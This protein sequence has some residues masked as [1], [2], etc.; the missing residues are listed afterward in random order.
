MHSL[1]KSLTIPDGER[2]RA[3]LLLGTINGVFVFDSE[4][5]TR[6][7]WE[8]VHTALKESF[9]S[10][11]AVDLNSPGTVYVGAYHQDVFRSNDFGITWRAINNGLTTKDI[12]SLALSHDSK[13]L[14]AGTQPPALFKSIDGGNTWVELESFSKI[15]SSRHWHWFARLGHSGGHVLVLLVDP[16]NSYRIYAGVEQGGLHRSNDK[17]ASW[18]DIGF[19]LADQ[20]N[21]VDPH[22]FVLNPLQ[23]K[24]SYLAD[25]N[26]VSRSSDSGMNFD[27]MRNGLGEWM[28]MSP[29][30]IHPTNPDLVFVGGSKKPPQIWSNEENFADGGL[31]R[32]EDGCETWKKIEN[33][34]P[35]ILTST[36]SALEL[37]VING[38]TDIYCGNTDGEVYQSVDMGE[39][40]KK[41]ISGV[42][43]ITKWGWHM[44]KQ[45]GSED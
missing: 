4:A 33:G 14:Y 27:G 32:S 34:L 2:E 11:L 10:T 9:I 1:I 43:S 40:W 5:S 42:P 21:S 17:G 28:Y 7:D 13:E 26:G 44:M 37:E 20:R 23:P 45:R 3:R 38:R 39:N 36:I 30:L 35:S 31:F 41:I 19:G 22:G 25:N 29:L 24:I 6:S 12:W 18:E 16:T 15:E 8:H